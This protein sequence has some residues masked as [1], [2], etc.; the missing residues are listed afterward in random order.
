MDVFYVNTIRV[1]QPPKYSTI[2]MSCAFIPALAIILRGQVYKM[3]S[4]TFYLNE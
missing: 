3:Y 4:C 1:L 2:I